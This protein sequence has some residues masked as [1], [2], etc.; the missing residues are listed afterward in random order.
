MA[1]VRA[2][3][4]VALLGALTLAAA[5]ARAQEPPL[6]TSTTTST[7]LELP[8]TTTAPP[9]N[10]VTTDTTATTL[11]GE[12]PPTTDTTLAPPLEDPAANADSPPET[13]PQVDLTVPPRPIAPFGV[14]STGPYAGQPAFSSFAGRVVRVSPRTARAHAVETQAALDAAIAHRD[15]LVA[16][17]AEL[18]AEL[19]RLAVEEREAIEALEGAQRNLSQRAADAYIRGNMVPVRSFLVSDS[20]GDFYNRLE[21]LS[22][23]LEADEQAVTDYGEARDAVDSEQAA[24]ADALATSSAPLV[25]AEQAVAAAQLEHEFASRELAVFLNGGSFVIHGFV[26]PVAAN[27][28]YSDSFGAPRMVGTPFEHWHEGTDILAP[29]GTELVA[30][31]RGVITSMGTGILGGITVWLKGESG[32]SYYYAHLT[33]YAPGIHTG[34]V[35]D[36]GT[37]LGYV[38][39]TGNAA[40]GP[41]HV[42]FEIHPGG[43]PAINPYP[44]LRVA[45]DQAQPAPIRLP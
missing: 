35:V 45:Q 30:S 33:G 39:T 31:E 3:G 20:A 14:T 34:L 40:G 11:P 7:T 41:P 36:A 8:T 44:I 6:D 32:T 21:L 16:R 2:A 4:L 25:A 10:P 19:G 38:G 24:I 12:V 27:Y 43:G 29:T 5:P 42:H 13:V 26:F 1:K 37:V 23:V 17:Q 22:V 15:G 28:S 18:Q 9:E